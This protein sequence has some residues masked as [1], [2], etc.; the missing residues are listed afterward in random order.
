MA[1]TGDPER[2]EISPAHAVV[3]LLFG[4]TVIALILGI[5]TGSI[6]QHFLDRPPPATSITI[7]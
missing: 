5:A 3:I 2:K 7:P 6:N 1:E 4:L